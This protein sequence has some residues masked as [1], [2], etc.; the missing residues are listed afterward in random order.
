MEEYKLEGKEEEEEE[1]GGV[2]FGLR[3]EE[4]ERAVVC[5]LLMCSAG[6]DKGLV[7]ANRLLSGSPSQRPVCFL[8][9]VVDQSCVCVCMRE[10]GG[11]RMEREIVGR[12]SV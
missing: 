2:W 6:S 10:R 4:G 12:P 7:G 1:E 8:G 5:V 9:L 11:W 3:M